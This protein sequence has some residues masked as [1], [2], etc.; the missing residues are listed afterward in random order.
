MIY[1]K[2]IYIYIHIHIH[3]YIYIYIHITT[4]KQTP[5]QG[6]VRLRA[7]GGE[8]RR[9]LQDKGGPPVNESNKPI[10]QTHTT[11]KHNTHNQQNNN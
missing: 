2:H 3:I 11:N 5:E 6:L 8:L 9:R 1:L 4:N 10:T 7:A